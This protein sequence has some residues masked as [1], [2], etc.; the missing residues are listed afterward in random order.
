M[1]EE[2]REP[3]NRL[4]K[5]LRSAVMQHLIGADLGNELLEP[6]HATWCALD[7]HSFGRTP[8][9]STSEKRR[10]SR[11]RAIVAIGRRRAI[12]APLSRQAGEQELKI[13]SHGQATLVIH[14]LGFL[15]WLCLARVLPPC[16]ALA[17]GV[18]ALHSVLGHGP[19]GFVQLV[20]VC[21]AQA[22]PSK[23][24]VSS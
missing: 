3:E 8:L 12:C 11:L 21:R 15:S 23:Q 7:H 16:W 22:Q 13:E 14:L 24:G 6:A 4:A 17:F 2:G 10:Y 20:L 18:Y 1:H 5:G 9:V 19:N